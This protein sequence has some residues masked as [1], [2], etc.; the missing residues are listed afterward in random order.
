LRRSS[1]KR[2]LFAAFLFTLV[3]FF[4]LRRAVLARLG[5]RLSWRSSRRC[6]F[7]FLAWVFLFFCVLS[8]CDDGQCYRLFF[9]LSFF[10]LG[11]RLH[12]PAHESERIFLLFFFPSLASTSPPRND[13]EDLRRLQR[14]ESSSFFLLTSFFPPLREGTIWKEMRCRVSSRPFLLFSFS[15]SSLSFFSSLLPLCVPS[16]CRRV[17]AA[18][19]DDKH[20]AFQVFGSS[21]SFFLCRALFFSF[22]HY[23][24]VSSEGKD[25]RGALFSSF[26]TLSSRRPL[27]PSPSLALA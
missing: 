24:L 14:P 12:A 10:L 11:H 21:F 16:H 18:Q 19:E 26:L 22:R 4:F 23:R 27:F 5:G 17:L 7:S 8:P 2:K 9:F 25:A 15:L 6:L 13:A 20:A 3:F 1:S